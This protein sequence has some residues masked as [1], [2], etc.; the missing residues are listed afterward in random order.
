MIFGAAAEKRVR[1]VRKRTHTGIPPAADFLR[2]AHPRP[3][4]LP[5][6]Y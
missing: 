6:T 2:T 3:S 5:H 1:C 4:R